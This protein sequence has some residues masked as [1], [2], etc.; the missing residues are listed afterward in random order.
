MVWKCH[1]RKSKHHVGCI[2]CRNINDQANFCF[3]KSDH[4]NC[5]ANVFAMPILAWQ[6]KYLLGNET[7][8][9]PIDPFNASST[10]AQPPTF[11][12]SRAVW[13]PPLS[14]MIHC[15]PHLPLVLSSA[16]QKRPRERLQR[17]TAAPHTAI[18]HQQRRLT[19]RFSQ[20][21]Q[22]YPTVQNSLLIEYSCWW[23]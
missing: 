15:R 11:N 9:A 13:I 23:K 6:K 22:Y 5:M 1:D 20:S 10:N 7:L 16:R 21:V 4:Q 2:L 12:D 3:T 19:S 17:R 18:A 8:V 14:L